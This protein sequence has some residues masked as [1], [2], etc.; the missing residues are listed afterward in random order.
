[1]ADDPLVSLWLSLGASLC[2][3]DGRDVPR[4]FGDAA[5]ECR[6]AR[7]GAALFDFSAGGRLL[8][9]GRDGLDLLHRISTADLKGLAVGA[10]RPTVFTD[11]KGR[12]VDL[13]GVFRRP[14]DLL[15]A[16]SVGARTAVAAHLER[17]IISEDVQVEDPE[18]A[19][20]SLLLW[21][22]QAAETAA[23]AGLPAA[24]PG[25]AVSEPDLTVARAAGPPGVGVH[26][27]VA[28]VADAAARLAAAGARPAGTE[29]WELLRILEGIP[30]YGR[31]ITPDWNPLEAGLGPA[32]S[33][34]KGC[35]VGQEVIARLHT[36]EK[37]RRALFRVA[38]SGDP[39]PLPA[40]VRI[41]D[42]EAGRLT[43]AAEVPGEG[44]RGLAY[45]R[46]EHATPGSR[47][48][49]GSA[50][51]EILGRCGSDPVAPPPVSRGPAGL[52]FRKFPKSG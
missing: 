5:A 50:R 28:R 46:L 32:I 35:Y 33:F 21:G 51:A 38:L 17:F 37:Q 16:T 36:Y 18:P 40:P 52:G 39:G 4:A 15:L 20:A 30:A 44:W 23:R 6:A 24:P 42:Q 43:S 27:R 2:D 3:A 10:T 49:A 22:P 1:M 14:D 25:E 19:W 7:Q 34:T 13:V 11:N 12:M 26:G 41:G 31:E 8:V 48:A 29:A 9:R 47:L 45:V